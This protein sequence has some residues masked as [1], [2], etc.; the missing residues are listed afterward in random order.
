[1]GAKCILCKAALGFYFAANVQNIYGTAVF[2]P[3]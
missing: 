2:N 3:E 1:M